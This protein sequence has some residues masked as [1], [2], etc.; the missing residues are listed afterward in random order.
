MPRTL[1]Q[2]QSAVLG[3]LYGGV[4]PGESHAAGSQCQLCPHW[5][6]VRPVSGLRFLICT[7]GTAGRALQA[8]RA[9]PRS[10]PARSDL[11]GCDRYGR[12]RLSTNSCWD[13]ASKSGHCPLG[14]SMGGRR[15]RTRLARAGGPR[16]A[17]G[18]CPLF[19]AP[20]RYMTGEGGWHAC[21][22][23]FARLNFCK[24]TWRASDCKM[25]KSVCV[26]V[27]LSVPAHAHVCAE[28]VC[29]H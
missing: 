8:G 7:L 13:S 6:G 27:S 10:G 12:P 1:T 26:C 4:G 23:T 14:H 19:P 21:V 17:R 20:F 24:S 18:S 16:G 9:G 28:K 15:T 2:G 3:G 11:R 22:K 25:E 29:N 5:Q